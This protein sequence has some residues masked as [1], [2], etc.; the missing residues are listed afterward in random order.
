MNCYTVQPRAMPAADYPLLF[1]VP[2]YHLHHSPMASQ[3]HGY[4]TLHGNH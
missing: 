4:D 2:E 3:P 1:V